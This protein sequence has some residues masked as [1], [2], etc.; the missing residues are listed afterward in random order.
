MNK[1]SI[2]L[3]ELY[4][5]YIDGKI[6]QQ[7]LIDSVKWLIENDKTVT[8]DRAV[9]YFCENIKLVS[10]EWYKYFYGLYLSGKPSHFTEGMY[11]IP[12]LRYLFLE[13]EEKLEELFKQ[14]IDNEKNSKVILAA[15]ELRRIVSGIILK[16]DRY[17]KIEAN[18]RL[19]K[20]YYII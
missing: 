15:I 11:K 10:K 2:N 5:K 18:R 12:I 20:K 9:E 4:K 19:Q 13:Y 3:Q 8:G 14:V 17:D 16:Y 7:L 1:I 6:E